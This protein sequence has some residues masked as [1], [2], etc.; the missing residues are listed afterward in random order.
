M[1]HAWEWFTIIVVKP[2]TVCLMTHQGTFLCVENEIACHKS[3]KD[4]DMPGPEAQFEVSVVEDGSITLRNVA[5]RGLL[6]AD[7]F[8]PSDDVASVH[9]I[10]AGF[11][12]GERVLWVDAKGYLPVVAQGETST[13]AELSSFAAMRRIK[14]APTSSA[15]AAPTAVSELVPKRKPDGPRPPEIR[16]N[17][18][19]GDVVVIAPE[20]LA[21]LKV[22]P[23]KYSPTTELLDQW[24]EMDESGGL[25]WKE[26]HADTFA[27]LVRIAKRATGARRT[28]SITALQDALVLAGPAAAA[29]FPTPPPTPGGTSAQPS[30]EDSEPLPPGLP[31]PPKSTAP[32]VAR[33]V[34]QALPS[35]LQPLVLDK[36]GNCPFCTR[37]RDDVPAPGEV[38]NTDVVLL[39]GAGRGWGFRRARCRH[40]PPLI[41]LWRCQRLGLQGE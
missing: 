39:R 36:A 3:L 17:A 12:D 40:Q 16:R 9:C 28:V 20:R 38:V 41:D 8:G 29:H 18:A 27:A 2:M 34:A 5:S 25:A 15:A 33:L 31:I 4:G 11:A 32:Y 7:T 23:F 30:A 22:D 37:C 6:Q 14:P 1:P 24:P 26:Q 19:T 35:E 21:R 10:R 13:A